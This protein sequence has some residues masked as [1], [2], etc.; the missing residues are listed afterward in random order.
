MLIWIN[1]NVFN[2]NYRGVNH[3][4][5]GYNPDGTV[6]MVTKPEPKGSLLAPTLRR[7]LDEKRAVF[8]LVDKS[9]AGCASATQRAKAVVLKQG[10]HR[11]MVVVPASAHLNMERLGYPTNDPVEPASEQDLRDLF[12]DCGLGAIPPI[13]PA[14]GVETWIDRTLLDQL[15]I[16]FDSG[17]PDGLVRVTHD[18][19][20]QLLGPV[21]RGNYISMEPA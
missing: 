13:G 17:D 5:G 12:P 10:R 2:G 15:E 4:C 8:D 14:Y 6:V 19:F 9:K 7:F 16:C 1:A 21:R 11:W 18:Q 3:F 20:E